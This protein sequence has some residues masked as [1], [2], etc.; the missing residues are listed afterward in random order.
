MCVRVCMSLSAFVVSLKFLCVC[1]HVRDL[2]SAC[3]LA[4]ACA[5][6]CVCVC[7]RSCESVCVCVCVWVCEFV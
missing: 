5:C 3:V 6:V 7:V 4:C 1:F 2:A